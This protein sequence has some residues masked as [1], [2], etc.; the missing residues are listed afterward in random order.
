MSTLN[1]IIGKSLLGMTKLHNGLIV[2]GNCNTVLHKNY[3]NMIGKV[4]HSVYLRENM[5]IIKWYII[6]ITGKVNIWWQSRK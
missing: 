4:S 1:E 5:L 3:T 6:L 2:L